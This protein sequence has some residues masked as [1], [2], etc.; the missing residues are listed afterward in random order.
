[1]TIV[2]VGSNYFQNAL[3][4]LGCRSVWVGDEPGCDIRTPSLDFDLAAVLKH[5]HLRPEVVIITDHLGRRVFPA[6]LDR[7]DTL[8]VWYGVDGPINYFWHHHFAPLFDLVL[9]DQKD[10]ARKLA[11]TTSAPVHWLPVAVDTRLYAGS[12]E[13]FRYDLSFVGVVNELVRPKRSRILNLIAGKYRVAV[14]GGRKNQWMPPREA[15]RLYRQSRMVLN[16]NLF[17]GVTTRM[18]EAMASGSLLLTEAGQNGLTDLFVPNEHLAVYDPDNLFDVIDYYIEHEEDRR[19][20]ADRGHAA[21]LAA[22]DIEH[23]AKRLLEYIADSRPHTGLPVGGTYCLAEGKTLFHA[24][25]RWP[26]HCGGERLRR[27]EDLLFRAVGS[28]IFDAET[29]FILGE[30]AR[31][32]KNPVEAAK[33]FHLAAEAGSVRA[34]IGLAV[35]A[36]DT[37]SH[38][39][40]LHLARLARRFGLEFPGQPEADRLTPDQHVCL[41][42]ILESAG[43]DLTPGFSR[44]HLDIPLW[45]AFE[46]YAAALDDSPA[47]TTALLGMGRIL[48]LYGAGTEWHMFLD[49]A[50]RQ[51]KNKTLLARAAAG[52]GSQAYASASSPTEARG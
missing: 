16:E 21:V 32:N 19:R 39:A 15:G 49:R 47:H 29:L 5:V 46:H 48:D 23:R 12:R 25:L 37:S 18:F 20:V 6:G 42:R 7:I 40:G 34:C 31:L 2:L 13:S 22:H 26:A 28:G 35:L 24:G 52:A 9:A 3:Q 50:S 36:R 33:R 30:I 45:N 17:D 27:A 8:K 4:S 41:G 44:H 51:D 38:E 1:M 43:H 10:C 11:R 14:A